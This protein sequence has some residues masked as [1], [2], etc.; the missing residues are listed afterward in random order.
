MSWPSKKLFEVASI[1]RHSIPPE[2]IENDTLYV[3]L[4]HITND[5]SFIGVEPVTNGKLA[6]SK[7]L[8][9]SEHLLYGKLRPYLKKIA[10]P[11]FSGICSTD[12]LPIKP[13]TDLDLGFLFH[14]LRTS[15]MV[16]YAT[17]RATGVNL[18]RLSP[19]TLANFDV[20]FPPLPE[21]KRIAAILDKADALRE[22]RRQAMAKLDELLQ[23]VFLDMFGDP[24]T[25]PKGWPEGSI[26]MVIK[27]KSD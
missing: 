4:E 3:G 1:D 2:K 27:D 5:G 7:F 18:P 26:E 15:Q 21:Q 16:D 20:P 22:K 24:V 17:T 9:T 14:Y 12:I 6:S 10:R 25:N 11:S 13:K 8:F 23:S 19:K